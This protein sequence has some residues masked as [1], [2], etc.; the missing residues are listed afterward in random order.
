MRI[1][2]YF[3][4]HFFFIL[5]GGKGKF[6][7][8]KKDTVIIKKNVISN[9]LCEKLITTFEAKILDKKQKYLWTD[10]HESDVRLSGFE[11]Y[12]PDLE[13]K[14]DIKKIIKSIDKYTGTTTKD[15]FLMLNKVV[16][17]KGS[18]G[19]GGGWHRD[20]VYTHQ[21]KVI[22]YLNDVNKKNGPLSLV[23]KSHVSRIK[24]RNEIPITTQRFHKYRGSFITLIAPKGTQIIF[25]ASCLHRGM[26]VEKGKRYALTLYTTPFKDALKKYHN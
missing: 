19:S 20:S 25:D 18:K 8:L 4:S 17:K 1:L 15:W 12:F 23:T 2:K 13:Q 16:V 3:L 7:V 9:S 10:D 26:P 11:K 6:S 22:W 24:L 14:L 21:V 5:F